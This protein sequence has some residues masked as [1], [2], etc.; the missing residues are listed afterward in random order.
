MTD[1]EFVALME[2]R[3]DLTYKELDGEYSVLHS[4]GVVTTIPMSSLSDISLD[5]LISILTGELEPTV[6]H[7]MTRVVGYYSRIDNWNKSKQGELKDRHKGD[8]AIK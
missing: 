7:H 2:S 5:T 1:R 4:S 8:Y 3:N 6:L